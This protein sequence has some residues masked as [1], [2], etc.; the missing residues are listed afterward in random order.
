MVIRDSLLLSGLNGLGWEEDDDAQCTMTTMMR[1]MVV[2]VR[3]AG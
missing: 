3:P 2:V 1:M